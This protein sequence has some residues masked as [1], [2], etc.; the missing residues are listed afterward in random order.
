[1]CALLLERGDEALAAT[2]ISDNGGP[3]ILGDTFQAKHIFWARTHTWRMCFGRTERREE[4][5]I[6]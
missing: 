2:Q 1:M 5:G 4:P 6:N 3:D